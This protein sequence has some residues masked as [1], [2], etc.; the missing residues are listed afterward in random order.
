MDGEA[1]KGRRG[2]LEDLLRH[3]EPP[4]SP[5]AT[6]AKAVNGNGDPGTPKFDTVVVRG[7]RRRKRSHRRLS[8]INGHIFNVDV[9]CH[10]QRR[11]DSFFTYK[12]NMQ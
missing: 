3:K 7:E 4:E 6:P 5:E 9:S 12:N 11:Q 8:I 1:L 10:V 2:S